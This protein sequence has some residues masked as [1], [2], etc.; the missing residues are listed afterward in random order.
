MVV[1]VVGYFRSPTS[2]YVKQ[3]SVGPGMTVNGQTSVNGTTNVNLQ[4]LPTQVLPT[5][6]CSANQIPKWN[7]AAW[8][9]A[10]DA[11]GGGG[12]T[13]TVTSVAT[14]AGLTGGPITTTGT[15]ALATTQLLPTTACAASEIPKWSGTAWTC[16]ADSGGPANAFVQGGNTFG[17]AAVLGTLDSF[18]LDLQVAGSRVMRFQPG[19]GT[20]GPNIYGG[21]A[22]NGSITSSK[23]GQVVGGGGRN[24]GG[25]YN[26]QT[27]TYTRSCANST[28]DDFATVGGGEANHA[29]VLWSTVSGGVS[30]TTGHT[31]ATVGGGASNRATGPQS[32]VGGGARNLASGWNATIPGGDFNVA[33]GTGSFAAGHRAKANAA[34][35]FVWADGTDMDIPCNTTNAWV[36]RASGG[37]T[38]F[39]YQDPTNIFTG[40]TVPAGG[41]SWSSVSDRAAKENFVA[42]DTTDVL[43]RLLRVPVS[44]WNYKS[45]DASIR[46]VGP[47]AQ[48]FR[49][50]FGVG[51]SE[52]MI[53]TVDAQGVA[54]AAIQ[55]LNAKLEQALGAR[56]ADV[57]AQR[58]EIARLREE[59]ARQRAELAALRSTQDDVAALRAAMTELLR[60]RSSGVT[61]TRLAP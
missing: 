42:V 6:P 57:A 48:D 29:G 16:A 45:Q 44:E 36:A 34:G 33:A 25:C 26:P 18:G 35:C 2:G 8:T 20:A 28:G 39:T 9:C 52:R 24:A 61:R 31:A 50:A 54:F 5:S 55:G 32:T 56:D 49:E 23:S 1:D 11:T 4:L 41:G 38:F 47:V 14:G 7:G 21:S 13:G 27:D 51:E 10:A 30:N 15:I 46:H 40:V 19:I 60:E 53:S 43:E 22:L 59:I 58:A 12:G 17:A 37:V 3:M